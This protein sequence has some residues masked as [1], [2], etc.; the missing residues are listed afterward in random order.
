MTIPGTG[1]QDCKTGKN[2]NVCQ[3]EVMR[4]YLRLSMNGLW[5]SAHTLSGEL[6]P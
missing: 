2:R 1:L 6:I 4:L 5:D 3:Q